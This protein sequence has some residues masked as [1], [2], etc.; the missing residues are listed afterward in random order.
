M[1]FGREY[2][3]WII[4]NSAAIIDPKIDNEGNVSEKYTKIKEFYQKYGGVGMQEY[5]PAE[6]K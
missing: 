4:N 2:K 3:L 5:N 1:K 6:E